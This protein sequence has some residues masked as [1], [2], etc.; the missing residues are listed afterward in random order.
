MEHNAYWGKVTQAAAGTD[1][2]A[3]DAQLL[4]KLA[5]ECGEY[6]RSLQATEG[7]VSQAFQA[8]Y[9]LQDRSVLGQYL[10]AVEDP[11]VIRIIFEIDE[12]ES[13]KI[14]DPVGVMLAGNPNTPKDVLEKLSEIDFEEGFDDE[15]IQDALKVNPSAAF[16]FN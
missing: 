10:Q 16:L 2:E 9:N 12:I 5:S 3:S 7:V 8:I 1:N 4:E 14:G 13:A 11:K 6:V 15:Q